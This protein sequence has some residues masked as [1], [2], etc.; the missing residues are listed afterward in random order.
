MSIVVKSQEKFEQC[1]GNIS[2]LDSWW[3]KGM[4]G[5]GGGGRRWSGAF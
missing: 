3:H 5:G 4:S 2:E 1:L